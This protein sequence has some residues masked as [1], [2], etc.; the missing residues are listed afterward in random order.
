MSSLPATLL[1]ADGSLRYN[2]CEIL[3]GSGSW[4]APAGKTSLAILLVSGG[5]GGE[6]GADG[7]WDDA[8]TPGAD[9]LGGK[10]FATTIHINE[11]QQF[12]YACGAGGA[13]NGGAGADTVFGAYTTATGTRFDGYTDIRDG[14]VYG[15]NGVTL[16]LDGSGDGGLGGKGGVKGNKKQVEHTG[17]DGNTSTVDRI[18]NRP[19]LGAEGVPGGSGCIVIWYEK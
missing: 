8:G 15:R 6:K 2:T 5:N 16:P 18:V 3:T 7:T 9:G 14:N 12:I 13:K 17:D 4:T 1:Q 11:Q 19:G 10:V